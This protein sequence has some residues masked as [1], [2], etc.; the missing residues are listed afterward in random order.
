VEGDERIGGSPL[1]LML[2]GFGREAVQVAAE[3]C[4]FL[5]PPRKMCTPCVH[6]IVETDPRGPLDGLTKGPA[7]ERRQNGETCHSTTQ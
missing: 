4:R 3:S 2:V 7:T 5:C 6:R 1:A